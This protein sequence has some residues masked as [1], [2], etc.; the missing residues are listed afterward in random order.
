MLLEHGSRAVFKWCCAAGYE[1]RKERGLS[2][3]ACF[4]LEGVVMNTSHSSHML[5]LNS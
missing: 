3:V 1:G 5:T 2:M 4:G